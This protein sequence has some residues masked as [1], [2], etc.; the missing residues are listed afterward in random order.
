MNHDS[1]TADASG[2]D[3]DVDT[4]ASGA[5]TSA[6]TPPHTGEPPFVNDAAPT[7][8]DNFGGSSHGFFAWIRSLAIQ[9]QPGWIGGVAS[10]IAARIGIDPI[11]V[12]GVLVVLALFAAPVLVFYAV[13]WLL[14]P[15]ADGRI[16][17]QRLLRGDPQ[18]ALAGI[19]T[20]LL[21]GLLTPATSVAQVLN[22]AAFWS[23]GGM[24]LWGWPSSSIVSTFFNLAVLAA[25][26]LFVVWLV[27][28]K[29]AHSHSRDGGAAFSSQT[30][31]ARTAASGTDGGGIESGDI[32]A[33]ATTGA[34][35]EPA[36][37]GATASVDELA[38]WKVQ[39]EAWRTERE[40]FNAEQ[41]NADRAARARWAAENKVRS[42]EFAAQAVA[43][44]ALRKA[45][46]PRISAAALFFTL[47]AGLIAG[48][49]SALAAYS[50][51]EITA[52]AA[53]IGVL[54][55][56]FVASV[57][58]IVS[59]ALRRRSGFLALVTV[60]L[61]LVGLTTAAVPR[62][63][64]FLLPNQGLS[65][66][67]ANPVIQPLGDLWIYAD[68][69]DSAMPGTDGRV[70]I[71]KMSGNIY[72]TVAAGTSLK[73]NATLANGQQVYVTRLDPNGDTVDG[74]DFATP[75]PTVE[76]KGPETTRVAT[77]IGEFTDG[78]PNL[79]IDAELGTGFV[80]ITQYAN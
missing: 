19:V 46:R 22:S 35:T 24:L 70:A 3:A 37:P 69:D 11:I 79:T 61:T 29:A 57:A 26:A 30:D 23:P 1:T 13:A 72:V 16:H 67:A 36:S 48:A 38:A 56:A 60:V 51:P 21:L 80:Q 6:P 42:Q 78:K 20:L 28:R 41:A 39:H 74:S 33:A 76:A 9:R 71:R 32:D 65:S 45:E 63:G 12:R 7:G 14:L 34:A 50:N 68:R 31:S 25:I 73:M 54:T 53:T 77:R 10:G 40:R 55:A 5:P 59:G 8:R 47:G 66:S 4:D 75:T 52:Y 64:T 18:P 17:A 27:K 58:M 49:G 15:D 43:H 44:R 2:V 62:E